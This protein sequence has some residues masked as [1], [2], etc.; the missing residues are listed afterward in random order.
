[1]NKI[2]LNQLIYN[3]FLKIMTPVY[4][5]VLC[6]V[7]IPLFLLLFRS[8]QQLCTVIRVEASRNGAPLSRE[9]FLG[10]K[11]I[12]NEILLGFESFLDRNFVKSEFNFQEVSSSFN[13]QKGFTCEPSIISVRFSEVLTFANQKLGVI[14]GEVRQFSFWWFVAIMVGIGLV[15][16]ISF[17]L[18]RRRISYELNKNVFSPLRSILDGKAGFDKEKLITEEVIELLQTFEES[19]KRLLEIEKE[20]ILEEENQKMIKLAKQISH[21]IRSPL[22]ALRSIT[23]E[24][25]SLDSISKSIVS[26]SVGRINEI[27]NGLLKP[28]LNSTSLREVINLQ[29]LIEELI[30]EK[31]FEKKI[32]IQFESKLNYEN[33][34]IQGHSVELYRAFS[35][36]INNAYEAYSEDVLPIYVTLDVEDRM[37]ILSISDTASGMSHEI[38]EKALIGGFSTKLGGNGLG[39]SYA[40]NVIE[41]HHGSFMVQTVPEEGTTIH[42]RLNT[43]KTPEWFLGRIEIKGNR[44]VCIDDDESFLN[45]YQ[46]KFISIKEKLLVGNDQ[47]FLNLDL[48]DED[49][50]F[51]DYD[52]GNIN[53]IELLSI[54]NWYKNITLVT[55]F[56]NEASIQEA[57][58]NLGVKILPKQIFNKVK[59][60]PKIEAIIN[61]INSYILIDDDPLIRLMWENAAKKEE[62]KLITYE[63]VSDFIKEE[64]LFSKNSKIIIDSQLGEGLRGE[65]E[66]EKIFKCGFENIILATGYSK[67]DINQ[68]PWIKEIVGKRPQFS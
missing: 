41:K 38:L 68:T 62:K 46:Q 44:V 56:Y 2:N 33:S 8:H 63:R 3:L 49:Q 26:N 27:T 14:S 4:V 25:E 65:E 34:F 7:Y 37:V 30:L 51:I 67:E 47:F 59:I 23:N 32:Q 43:V 48:S 15:I 19:Q 60:I 16:T 45:L 6:F 28:S 61:A 5:I 53:G 9:L 54:K 64:A 40:K 35:N 21:D 1:M 11:K 12:A 29:I 50:I 18:L 10:D 66:A 55:S 17:H 31:N 52:L 39:L 22:E 36:I 42:M 20:K 57:C 24:L 13:G 58:G